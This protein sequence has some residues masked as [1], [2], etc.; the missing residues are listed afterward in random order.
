MGKDVATMGKDA[1][2]MGTYVATIAL[3]WFHPCR[4]GAAQSGLLGKRNKPK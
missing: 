1:A 2:T 4:A 3:Q